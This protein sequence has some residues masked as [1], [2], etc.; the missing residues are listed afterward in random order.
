MSIDEAL[1]A[2]GQKPSAIMDMKERHL[3]FA[4][5]GV[6]IRDHFAQQI[7]IGVE[8]AANPLA[9]DLVIH[10]DGRDAVGIDLHDILFI[11]FVI[12]N[13]GAIDVGGDDLLNHREGFFMRMRGGEKSQDE[14]LLLGDF[15]DAVEHV[16]D[17]NVVSARNNNTDIGGLIGGQGVGK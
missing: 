7:L 13:D 5:L 2:M 16:G 15:A 6:V 3:L 17:V 10:D 12:K 11:E 9:G 1:L 8:N 4:A 14:P